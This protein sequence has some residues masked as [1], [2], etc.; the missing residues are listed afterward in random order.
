MLRGNEESLLTFTHALRASSPVSR[1]IEACEQTGCKSLA[2]SVSPPKIS[3]RKFSKAHPHSFLMPSFQGCAGKLAYWGEKLICNIWQFLLYR[4][5]H[6][7]RQRGTLLR[8]VS[9]GEAGVRRRSRGPHTTAFPSFFRW[10]LSSLVPVFPNHLS[11]LPHV[12]QNLT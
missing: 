8:N 12:S 4:S 5:S 1:E 7:G 10:S 9:V 6:C 3:A 2:V 11:S